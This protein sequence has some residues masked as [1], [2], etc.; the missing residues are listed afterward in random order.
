VGPY[1][2][3]FMLVANSFIQLTLHS[4]T[5]GRQIKDMFNTLNMVLAPRTLTVMV[6]IDYNALSKR[7][8]N[9]TMVFH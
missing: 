3:H 9:Q 7:K 2:I 5:Q 8:L 1:H 6:S 4:Y